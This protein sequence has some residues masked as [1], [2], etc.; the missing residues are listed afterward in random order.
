MRTCTHPSVQS[1]RPVMKRVDSIMSFS[2]MSYLAAQCND[3]HMKQIA[4]V[5]GTPE[6]IETFCNALIAP[7]PPLC[8]C[9]CVCVCVSNFISTGRGRVKVDLETRKS[10]R[11]S[12]VRKHVCPSVTRAVMRAHAHET[13]CKS[14]LSC[15]TLLICWLAC[16]VCAYIRRHTF[17]RLSKKRMCTGTYSNG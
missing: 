17:K 16:I 15:I 5:R 9:V 12:C 3:A 10:K 1:N 6:M 4:I 11:N 13:S 2:P 8:V 7:S 14:A